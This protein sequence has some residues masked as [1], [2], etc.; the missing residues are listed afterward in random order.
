M[1]RFLKNFELDLFAIPITLNRKGRN[2]A[3]SRHGIVLTLL[4][5]GFIIW[6]IYSVSQELFLKKNPNTINYD[7]FQEV[8]PSMELNKETFPLAFGVQLPSSLGLSFFKD[9]E[10]YYPDVKVVVTRV[11][12]QSDG[13]YEKELE[14]IDVEVET[15]VPQH[16]GENWRLFSNGPFYNLYCIKPYQPLF[17]KLKIAGIE[18]IGEYTGFRIGI[19][20]CGKATQCKSD[21]D[22]SKMLSGAWINLIYLQ[23]TINPQNFTHPNQR[24]ISYFATMISPNQYKSAAIKLTHLD[25]VDDD[26]WLFET[27]KIKQFIKVNT[28]TEYLDTTPDPDGFLWKGIID[29]GQMM[30]TYERR[31]TRLQTVLAQIQGSAATVILVLIVVLHPFSQVKFNETLINELFDVKIKKKNGNNRNDH[32]KKGAKKRKYSVEVKGNEKERAKSS[33]PNRNQDTERLETK[34]KPME[35]VGLSSDRGL[36][37]RKDKQEDAGS[38]ER[39]SPE[40]G[41][42]ENRLISMQSFKTIMS[43]I[44]DENDSPGIPYRQKATKNLSKNPTIIETKSMNYGGRRSDNRLS[45]AVNKPEKVKPTPVSEEFSD[46]PETP[47]KLSE[48]SF[49]EENKQDKDQEISFGEEKKKMDLKMTNTSPLEAVSSPLSPQTSDSANANAEKRAQISHIALFD[50]KEDDEKVRQEGEGANDE[51]YSVYESSKIDISVWEYLM[52]FIKNTKRTNEKFEVLDIGMRNVK[53]RMDILNIMK[54]FREL[55]KLKTL[56][57]EEDQLVLF[58]AIPKAE[59]RSDEGGTLPKSLILKNELMSSHTI[60]ERILRKSTFIELDEDQKQIRKS[61]ERLQMKLK[62]SKI[63]SRLLELFHDISTK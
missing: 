58:N 51:D 16:F 10:V 31:Y 44:D 25:V 22:I 7:S 42:T 17:D 13:S 24:F 48:I 6:L 47:R 9:E 11:V 55:D 56:L 19:R 39:G 49:K 27:N 50:L 18:D 61:Y 14:L 26:G 23:S 8:P 4:F 5:A 33:L 38:P 15:C 57:L 45:L 12:Q 32:A 46:G 29:L 21:H 62:K 40:R 20:R 36:I 3:H 41:S 60:S 37:T 52:S 35:T 63:D 1:M 28:P 59:I 43:S 30:T 2:K 34:Q 54:K 53:E